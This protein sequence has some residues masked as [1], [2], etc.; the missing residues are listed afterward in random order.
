M[1]LAV[2]GALLIVAV[3]FLPEERLLTLVVS[4]GAFFLYIA[5]Y[6]VTTPS[7]DERARARQLVRLVGRLVPG[8]RVRT[9]SAD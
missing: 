1:P 7:P 9:A 2:V 8:H 5:L 6:L 4:A 3:R